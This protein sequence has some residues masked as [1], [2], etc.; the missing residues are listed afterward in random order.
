ML[1]VGQAAEI[2]RTY[3]QSDLAEFAALSGSVGDTV[4]EPLIAALFSYL[5]GVDLPGSGTNYLKQELAFKAPAPLD[6]PLLARVE[7]T[8]LRPEKHLVDLWASCTAP[9]G[10]VLCEG[11]SL[12]KAKDVAG[13]FG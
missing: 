10:T 11:R 13:A 12:V 3:T 2:R 1:T 7:I 6:T 9:D 5:L 4:P 8:R